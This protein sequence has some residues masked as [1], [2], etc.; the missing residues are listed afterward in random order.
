MY[1]LRGPGKRQLTSQCALV[2]HIKFST[3]VH[4]SS[5]FAPSLPNKHKVIECKALNCMVQTVSSWECTDGRS[6]PDVIYFA[7]Q[8]RMLQ[9]T[10]A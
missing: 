3:V 10:D 6:K 2:L 5:A 9:G 7:K 8:I 1:I 4:W